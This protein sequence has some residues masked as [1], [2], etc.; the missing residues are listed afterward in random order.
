[1]KDRKKWR[2]GWKDGGELWRIEECASAERKLS[3]C[4]GRREEDDEGELKVQ[5]KKLPRVME[6]RYL[7]STVQVDSDSKIEVAKRIAARWN[8]WR[9]VLGVL[10]DQKVPLSVKGKLHKVVVRPAMIYSMETLAVM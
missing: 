1:M 3:T 7:G 8:S 2:K 6:F 4:V 9:K 5:G 10:C